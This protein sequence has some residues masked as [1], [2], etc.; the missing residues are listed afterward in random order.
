MQGSKLLH[1]LRARILPCRH[2]RLIKQ[3]RVIEPLRRGHLL[4]HFRRRRLCVLLI[5][6]SLDLAGGA[7]NLNGRMRAGSLIAAVSH[8]QRP[9]AAYTA[10]TRRRRA[11]SWTKGPAPFRG[12]QHNSDHVERARQSLAL[13]C[14]RTENFWCSRFPYFCSLGFEVV[15]AAPSACMYKPACQA[16]SCH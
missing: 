15:N 7:L 3:P 13:P 2:C 9:A 16:H 8:P 4:D 5:E 1:R 12:N 11:A 6:P 14:G 10:R